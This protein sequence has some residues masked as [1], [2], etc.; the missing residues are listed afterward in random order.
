MLNYGS[1]VIDQK[2][3]QPHNLENN[4]VDSN[5]LETNNL[6]GKHSTDHDAWQ[7][8]LHLD[9]KPNFF[10]QGEQGYSKKHWSLDIASYYYSQPFINVNG[11]VYWQGRWQKVSGKAWFDREWGSQ[12]LAVDQQGWDWFSLRLDQNTALMVYR[13]RSDIEDYV[14]GSLMSYQGNIQTLSPEDIKVTSINTSSSTIN[15]D[16]PQAF[17]L[18]I[19]K[20]NIALTVSVVNPK[21]IMRFGIEYFEGMVTFNGTHQGQ[22]FLEMTGYD[23]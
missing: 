22:G 6:E 15:T 1:T 8:K 5:N 23:K 11:E 16:Y 3:T 19:E 14:Y 2:L 4:N 13:I 10:L 7:V 9:S 17:K 18:V 21:Q 20:K 12:M